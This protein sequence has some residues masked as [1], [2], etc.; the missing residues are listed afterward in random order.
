MDWLKALL[1]AAKITNGALDVDALMQSV[2]AE[3]PKHAVP[4]DEFISLISK[5]G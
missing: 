1:E 5:A 3:F 4:K 2:Q